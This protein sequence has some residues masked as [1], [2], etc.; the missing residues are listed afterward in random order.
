M[1][2]TTWARPAVRRRTWT[3]LL[4]AVAAALLVLAPGVGAAHL[5][6]SDDPDVGTSSVNGRVEAIVRGGNW[7][8]IGGSF[9]TVGGKP[10][11]GL[12]RLDLAGKVDPNWQ[13]DVAG[14]V[15][16]LA[17][18]GETLYVGGEF[19]SVAGVPRENLAA[20][21]TPTAAVTGWNPA[22]NRSVEALATSGGD[23]YVGGK[24]ERIG[25][26]NTSR[27]KLAKVRADGTVDTGFTPSPNQWVAALV[28]TSGRLYAGGFFT[29][30]GGG[31]QRY[32][33]ALDPSTGASH[34]WR[35]SLTCPVYGLALATTD[36]YVACGG[37][38]GSALAFSTSTGNRLWL[39]RT[40]GNVHAVAHI[41]DA[42]YFGGHFTTM[43]GLARKKGGAVDAASGALTGWNPTFNSSFGVFAMLADGGALW[44][45]GD[46]TRVGPTRKLRVARFSP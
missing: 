39:V 30:I 4:A 25:V 10:R 26:D 24:F 21:S 1:A 42:V 27:P 12:A 31:G 35:P 9:T 28:L 18:S 22:P 34:N 40:N 16:T 14:R 44:A 6:V 45:G 5:L 29:A 38:G 36:I 3:G 2:E 15:A 8:Y 33:A 13:A 17:V 11:A 23:V 37:S 20:V 41:G 7:V 43:G 32:L 19:T 46:F